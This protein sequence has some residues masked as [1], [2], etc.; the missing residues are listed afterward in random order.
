MRL[1]LS[2]TSTR[3]FLALP[4]LALAETARTHRRPRPR[5]LPLMAWGYLQYRLAG[6][7][8]TRHGGGGPGMKHPPDQI[9]DTGVYGLTRNPMYLGHLIFLTG[10][11][12]TTRSRAAGI[13]TL[14]LIPWFDAHAASDEGQLLDLFGEEYAAYRDAVPRWL[15][16]PFGNLRPRPWS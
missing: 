10:L 9:V 13:A 8:R 14:A 6:S 4:A 12:L 16:S 3:T 2:S 7:Y 5:Y 15:P 11:T 1:S